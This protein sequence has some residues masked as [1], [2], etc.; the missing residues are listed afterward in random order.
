MGRLSKLSRANYKYRLTNDSGRKPVVPCDLLLSLH[1]PVHRNS[2]AFERPQSHPTSILAKLQRVTAFPQNNS[3]SLE[4]RL[5]FFVLTFPPLIGVRVCHDLTGIF[6]VFSL[7]FLKRTLAIPKSS[8]EFING[9]SKKPERLMKCPS[10]LR[11][12]L[13]RL[14]LSFILVAALSGPQS[15]L[16]AKK[17]QH[18]LL[19]NAA[20]VTV[21]MP[22]KQTIALMGGGDYDVDDAFKWMIRKSGGG[23]F[24]VIRVTDTDNYNGYIYNTLGGKSLGLTSVETLVIPSREAADDPFVLSRIAG[25][26]ALFIAG[27]DQSSYINYWTGT[28][29]Q[30][31]IQNLANRNVPIGGTSAGLAVLGQFCFAA[32]NGTVSSASALSN[33][34]G[35]DVT[36]VRDF[37]TFP[38]LSLVIADPHLE[39]RDRMGRLITFMARIVN[40][41]WSSTARGIGVD[42][43]TAVLVEGGIATRVANPSTN[44]PRSVYFMQTVG[45]PE[46]MAIKTP[47][48]YPSGVTVKKISAAG[49]FDLRNWE[50]YDGG[51]ISYK[52]TVNQGV[53]VSSQPSGAVY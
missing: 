43:E 25:A 51:A 6:N 26:D 49:S 11:R 30:R 14:S 5:V 39:P 10:L 37:L 45:Y 48:N 17:Y 46:R 16:A 29:V 34:L 52:I 47:L 18:Y 53:L 19:G 33:P 15:A 1:V 20:D 41:G 44:A 42:E 23:N 12:A 4:Q 13:L 31:E 38:D 22:T 32:L 3:V 21:R 9:N 35:K 40:D 2:I 7:T 36:L 8:N 24:V 50:N 28:G 27:G